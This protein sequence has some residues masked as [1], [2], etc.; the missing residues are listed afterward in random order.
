MSQVSIALDIR[1]NLGECPRWDEETQLLYWVDINN[2]QLHRF[3]PATGQ[4]DFLTFEQEIGCFALRKQGGF[5]LGMRHGFYLLD[6]WNTDL[7]FM[8]DPEAHLEKNRF[9]DGRVDASG[10]LW[11]GSVYPPKDYNGANIYSLNPDG[12]VTH[13][14]GDLLTANGIAFSPDSRTLYY[15][16]TPSHAIM[17]ADFDLAAGTISN[18]R[19]FHQ[20]PHGQ[21]RPDGACVDSEGYYWTALYEGGRVVR[22]NPAGEIVQEIH[23]PVRCPTMPAFGGAD[24]KTLY[25]TS[26]SSRPES[27]LAEYPHS[28]ALFKVQVEVAGRVEYRFGG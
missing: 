17:A 11:A 12:V 7:Q 15:A 8:T 1:A 24:L 26:V 6:G 23:L 4:D 25:I 10:R 18:T 2:K 21:G 3:N 27:E 5:V 19:V 16:D 9:N 20:F 14:V 22:L 28:G 13:Q